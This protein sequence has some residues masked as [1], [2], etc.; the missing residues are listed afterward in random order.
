MR[1]ATLHPDTTGP[2]Y[3]NA[4]DERP[5]LVICPDCGQLEWWT[6]REN[7]DHGRCRTGRYPCACDEH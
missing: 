4:T 1:D 6:E 5:R 2:D 7:T 3:D